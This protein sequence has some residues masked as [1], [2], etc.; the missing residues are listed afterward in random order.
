VEVVDL[1]FI[2]LESRR[3]EIA[4]FSVHPDERWMQQMARN[5][6]M[7]GC[8]AV[9]DCRYLLHDRCERGSHLS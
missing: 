1:L 2:H 8:G 4:G 5:A 7:E 6:T 9:R 3:V